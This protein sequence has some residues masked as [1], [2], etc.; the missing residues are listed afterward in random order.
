[1]IGPNYAEKAESESLMEYFQVIKKW[2][3]ILFLFPGTTAVDD[4]Y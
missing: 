2:R 3:F 1:M 4:T